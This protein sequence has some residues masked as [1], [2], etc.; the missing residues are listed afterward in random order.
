MPP[1]ILYGRRPVYE[2]LRAGRRQHTKLILA[3]GLKRAELLGSIEEL[4]QSLGIP[5]QTANR[6]MFDNRFGDA[7]HQGVALETSPYPYTPWDDL[8]EIAKKRGEPPF[9]LVL[10]H[11]QDPQNLGSILRTAEAAGVHGV[12]IPDRRAAEV[13]PAVVRASAGASEHLAVVRV[14]NLVHSMHDLKEDGLW[15]A[16]LDAGSNS[17]PYTDADLNGPIGLVVGTE[18]EGLSR[19]VGE[20]CDYRIRLP[21]L[22]QV[23]SLNAGVATAIAVYD[24]RRRRDTANGAKKD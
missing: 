17:V 12:V 6:Q 23:G 5:V 1:E 2:S 19:L 21:M 16:G 15:L 24:I 8:A 9:V 14:I 13:T 18:G 22:G 20:N 11:L 7:N 4:A 3:E 10:D